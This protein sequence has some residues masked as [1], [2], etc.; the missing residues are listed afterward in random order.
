MKFPTVTVVLVLAALLFVFWQQT[1]EQP[2]PVNAS[3]FI[4]LSAD[5]VQLGVAVDWI[6]T[7]VPELCSE[8][9]GAETQA[10]AHADCVEKAEARTSSC[11]RMLYDRFPAVVASDALF[12][13]VSL[14]A[15]S[16]LVARSGLVD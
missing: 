11:R 16:C 4:N 8:V 15:M 1:R 2:E 7:Q 10:K 9:V 13:D 6:F 12:R 14:T 3:R 5:P